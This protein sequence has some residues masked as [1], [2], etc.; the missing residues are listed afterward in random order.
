MRIVFISYDWGEYCIRI[1]NALSKKSEVCLVLAD[2]QA[3]PHLKRVGKNLEFREFHKPRLRQ[4][5]QQ[6]KTIR[7][8]FRIIKAFKPDVIHLQQGHFWFNLALSF[9]KKYPLVITI[10]DPRHHLGDKGSQN[11]PQK[12]Y[13]YG[14]RK[15][16]KIVV[17]VEP[18]TKIMVKEVGIPKDRIH[19]IPH[20]MLGDDSEGKE[21]QEEKNVILYFGRIWEYK[22]LKYLIK[23]E[24][25]ISKEIPDIKII[26]AG[27]GEDFGHYRK[28]M[29]NPEKFIVDNDYV[30]NAKRVEY[31]RRAC[32]VV[33]PYVEATQSGVI[34]IAYMFEKAI[35]ATNVGGLP[36]QV[37]HGKTGLLVPPR[38][39][40][41]L[42]KAIIRLLKDNP[43][44]KKLAKN[45][46]IKLESEWSAEAISEKLLSVYSEIIKESSHSSMKSLES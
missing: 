22:G 43:L 29:I 17:H 35:V 19:V 6:I 2:E 3:Q 45:G 1:A 25:L 4:P 20:V 42:S 41:Q 13:D 46:K 44:R 27:R 21:I 16:N 23:A 18:M 5:L 31:F 39:K 32:L 14:F 8:I 36:E 28:M 11:T 34:P 37:D 26:I 38:D 33:L 15:A 40:M 7:E 10:H 9:L 12:L 24:P 30:S